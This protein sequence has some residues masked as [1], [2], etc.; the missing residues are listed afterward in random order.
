MITY[1]NLDIF[2]GGCD[3]LV[4][5]VN[6]VG[7]SGAGLALAFRR[8]Y[9]EHFESYR[10][11][12]RTGRLRPGT[13]HVDDYGCDAH[14]RYLIALPTKRHWRDPSRLDDIER[15]TRALA[16]A[17]HEHGIGSIAIPRLGA[18]LGRLPWE[19]VRR[20]IATALEGAAAHCDILIL[21]DPP[22]PAARADTASHQP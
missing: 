13:V 19:T 8:R 1:R 5:P 21:A 17:I 2:D 12:C 22:T 9:P 10:N 4:N 6:C 16:D 11:A 14:P 20:T 18:G 7:V 15:A 3:A